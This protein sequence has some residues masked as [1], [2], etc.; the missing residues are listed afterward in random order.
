MRRRLRS[1]RRQARGAVRCQLYFFKPCRGNKPKVSQRCLPIDTGS[2]QANL[3][4]D[5]SAL[6]RFAKQVEHSPILFG[7]TAAQWL[8][9]GD[10]EIDPM[11]K[12]TAYDST[13][14]SCVVEQS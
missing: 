4:A 10:V 8:E 11:S 14:S 5:D 2:K 3:P 6:A 13:Q 12:S 9:C 1:C 7:H